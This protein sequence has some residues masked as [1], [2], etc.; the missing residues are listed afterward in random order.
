VPGRGRPGRGGGPG[1]GG[2][3]ARVPV[4]PAAEFP[5]GSDPAGLAAAGRSVL[6]TLAAAMPAPVRPAVRAV[7]PSA[8]AATAS[9]PV[10]DVTRISFPPGRGQRRP[11]SAVRAQ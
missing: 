7:I 10:S 9:R 8:P 11:D 4:E 2:G 6:A 3:A 1:A 5:P